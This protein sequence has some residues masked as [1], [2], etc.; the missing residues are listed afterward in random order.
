MPGGFLP[1]ALRRVHE[2]SL[3][4]ASEPGARITSTCSPLCGRRSPGQPLDRAAQLM[5]AHPRV[6]LR[7]VEVLVSEQLLDLAEVRARAEQLRGKH[8]AQSVGRDRL[9]L[10]T[11]AASV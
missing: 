5:C 9:R 7:R 10:V 8:V 6:A 2:A 11:P 4:R 1:E 3:G